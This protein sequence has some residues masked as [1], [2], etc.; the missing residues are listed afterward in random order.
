MHFAEGAYP[1][2]P[3]GTGHGSAHIHDRRVPVVLAGVGI[4]PGRHASEAGP[5]DV[6]P[7]LGVL[8]GLEPQLESDTRVLS[9][10]LGPDR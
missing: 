9:E 7:T 3:N 4:V 8:L 6:A 10:A 5:E 1:G 2:G